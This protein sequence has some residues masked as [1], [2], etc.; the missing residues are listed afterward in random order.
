MTVNAQG[1]F[2]K[3]TVFPRPWHHV[4]KR[5]VMKWG[6]TRGFWYKSLSRSIIVHLPIQCWH[7]KL[8]GSQI[9]KDWKRIIHFWKVLVARVVAICRVGLTL[10]NKWLVYAQYLGTQ[11]SECNIWRWYGTALMSLMKALLII[12]LLKSIGSLCLQHLHMFQFHPALC[13]YCTSD[14]TVPCGQNIIIFGYL[15]PP[16]CIW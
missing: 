10:G 5:I 9:L 6:W 7:I 2:L 12:T 13:K 15:E 1:A 16:W 8:G 4:R 14:I 3:S 11:L